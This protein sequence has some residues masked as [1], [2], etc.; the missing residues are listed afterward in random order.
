MDG[1]ADHSLTFLK[2]WTRAKMRTVTRVTLNLRVLGS[3][4]RRLTANPSTTYGDGRIGAVSESAAHTVLGASTGINPPVSRST[5]TRR[6]VPMLLAAILI[7]VAISL[8]IQWFSNAA[9]DR[10]AQVE[11]ENTR[12]TLEYDI[13][14]GSPDVRDAA[15]DAWL[16]RR[17][18]EE[19]DGRE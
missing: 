11:P 1:M 16:D 6:S 18:R 2:E 8:A 15:L 4:P 14:H 13:R 17:T 10:R 9:Y 5:S 19:R 3:I 12:G 7:A